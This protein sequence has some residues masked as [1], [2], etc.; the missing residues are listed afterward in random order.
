MREKI[1]HLCLVLA[2]SAGAAMA[3]AGP[4]V[5]NTA[6]IY[7]SG[8]V[9]SEAVPYDT[10]LISG[11]ESNYKTTFAQN[12]YVFINKGANQ[13]VKV[14]DEF[15]V[16]RPVKDR[17]RIRWFSPQPALLR[18]MGTQY[19][20]LGR[21]RV[22]IVQPNVSTAQVTY[23][24]DYLQRE[25]IVRPF[26][27]RPAPPLKVSAKFDRFAPPSGRP[28][29]MVVSA[30]DFHQSVGTNDVVY[31]N[32]GSAQGVKVGDYF[33]IF[34]YQGTRHET[35]YQER[36]M[37]HAVYGFG[38]TPSRYR[39]DNL[40]REVLGEGIVLRVSPNASTVLI[41][42][43]QREAYLGDYVELE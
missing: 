22:V 27:Q 1:I 16:M 35:A 41:T 14:G 17:G 40:P 9:T 42:F 26:A 8:M 19:M 32:L 37:A 15:L 24:C 38:S 2:L 11:E 30:K 31:I 18:A 21:L 33:R 34:R 13:G 43:S 25:D 6:D 20:D 23:A 39:W 4:K 29:A 3:Q 7:C 12:D 10:Y 28:A 36:G 5:P